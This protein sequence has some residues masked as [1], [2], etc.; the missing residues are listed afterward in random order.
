M[1]AMWNTLGIWI[2]VFLTLAVFSF[3]YKDNPFYKFAEHL[4][5]GVA[6]GYWVVL[7]IRNVLLPNLFEP[8][9]LHF[10]DPFLLIPLFLGLVLFTRL[11]DR[12]SYL[13]RWGMAAV[14]G[15]F[16]GLAIFGFGGGDLIIQIRSNIMPFLDKV[17]LQAFDSHPGFITFLNVLSNPIFILGTISVLFYFFFSKEHTGALGIVS[18]VGIYLLMISFGASYGNTVMARISLFIDRAQFGIQNWKP[19]VIIGVLMIIAFVILAIRGKDDS[20]T[21]SVSEM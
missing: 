4:F 12:Y 9:F 21:P 18:K 1:S 2:Q 8:L 7:Q 16:A 15:I 14:V 20:S 5:V 17:A 3:L 6:T 19:T 11:I 13:S 10:A